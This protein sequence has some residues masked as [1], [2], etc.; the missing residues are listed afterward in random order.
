MPAMRRWRVFALSIIFTISVIWYLN[1]NPRGW[2]YGYTSY[3]PALPKL[4]ANDGRIHWSKL[5]EK[6]PVTSYIAYPTG[7]PKKI[8]TVQAEQPKEDAKQK[9]ERLRRKQKVLESFV[10]SWEGYKGHAWLRDEVA[11]MT[12]NWKD[13]FGGWAAT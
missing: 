12:G 4:P 2:D 1:H 5:P 10:H 9:E 3:I 7:T 11:P 6:Y 13:T 8:P